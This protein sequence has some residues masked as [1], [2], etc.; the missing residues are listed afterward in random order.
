MTFKIIIVLDNLRSCHNVGSIIRTANGFNIHDFIFIGTCPYPIIKDD[1]RLRYQA[2]KQTKQIAKT[3]LGAELKIQG[4]YY[5][6]GSD[7]LINKQVDLDL[8]CVEQTKDSQT[9]NSF[10]LEN[11]AY[12]IFGNELN[13]ISSKILKQANFQVSI[14]ML[15]DKE[16]FNVAVASGIV[17]YQLNNF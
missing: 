7:F 13:G 1:K 9:L 6:E 2:L 15:G 14:P 10:K 17:L 8:I 11:N 12:L 16:S 3:A 4:Q 5:K